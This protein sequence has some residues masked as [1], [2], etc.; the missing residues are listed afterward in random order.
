MLM[1][2]L[3]AV[4]PGILIC[5]IVIK[6]RRMVVR[7]TVRTALTLTR[8]LWYVI[9][10]DHQEDGILLTVRSWDKKED[11]EDYP[12][13]FPPDHRSIDVVGGIRRLDVVD[14]NLIM[15]LNHSSPSCY[16]S[17]YLVVRKANI[18]QFA[19]HAHA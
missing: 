4:I 3:Q 18:P 9:E 12:I 2:F 1:F 17:S 6:I 5:V 19:A 13:F 7:S 8:G 16:L 11:R 14:F 10:V 15:R